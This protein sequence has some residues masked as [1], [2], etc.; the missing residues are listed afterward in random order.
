MLWELLVLTGSITLLASAVQA[1]RNANAST[2]SRA[3]VFAVGVILAVC[4]EWLA[5]KCADLFDRRSSRLSERTQKCCLRGFY[6]GLVL[7]L[8][9]AAFVGHSVSLRLLRLR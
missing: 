1:A 9:L 3:L 4:Y 5:H 2:G 6:C 7:F 8:P